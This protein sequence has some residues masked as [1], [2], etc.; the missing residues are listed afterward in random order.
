MSNKAINM[1]NRENATSVQH[2][3]YGCEES[4]HQR[5]ESCDEEICVWCTPI[6]EVC[7]S[8]GSDKSNQVCMDS[9]CTHEECV[10]SAMNKEYP[11][12]YPCTCN[13]RSTVWVCE[14]CYNGISLLNK[15]RREEFKKEWYRIMGER[16]QH[17][18]E[19]ETL[20]LLGGSLMV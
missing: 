19:R 17:V 9:T 10:Y 20:S 6:F 18:V 7:K 1:K 4:S 12:S 3:D 13:K 11:S 14:A 8:C 15:K 5:C 16:V 2:M